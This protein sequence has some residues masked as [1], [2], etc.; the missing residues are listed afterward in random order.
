[1]E[2][3]SLTLLVASC[4]GLIC[5]GAA[6]LYFWNRDR[7]SIWLLW[8]SVP[9][10]ISGLA[11]MSYA[12]PNWATDFLSI[13]PGNAARLTTTAMLWQGARVFQGHKPTWLMLALVPAVWLALCLIPPFFQ[14]M[15]A[16]VV[17]VSAFNIVLCCLSAWELHRGRAEQL[18]S[19]TPAILVFLS[20]SVLMAVRIAG[21]SVLP[22]PMGALPLDPTWMAI[23]NLVV[24]AHCFFLG[25]LLIALTKERLELQQRNIALVDPLTGM[26]NRRAFMDE[27]ARNG[28]RR[29]EPDRPTALLVLDLDHFKSINDRNGH[30]VGDKVL[31]SFAKVAA[32]NV[33]P[34]DMLFRLGGE[35]F[36]FLLPDT[37]V[38]A[39]LRV[40]ERVR[41]AFAAHSYVAAS[42]EVIAATVSIGIANAEHAGF[43][44][45]VLLAAAD[46][47]LYEAKSR[48]RNRIV[49]ADPALLARP[50]GDI[51][52]EAGRFRA[53]VA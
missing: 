21:I 30:D 12:R 1:M 23:F 19:R 17:G 25:L 28:E 43:D 39:A 40:A 13:G 27:V 33:R 11:A 16:R 5:I 29:G 20:F 8:W 10:I 47:A 37:D 18:A 51:I 32:A 2:L 15:P 45:E 44:L 7:R 31:A 26:M 6:L 49:L 3:D 42:G 53:G 52:P 38:H 9:F 34:S 50:D 24:F 22:F 4:A 14:S 36:C 48:G 35:E 41:K 46:A